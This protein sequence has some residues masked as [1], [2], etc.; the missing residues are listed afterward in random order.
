MIEIFLIPNER[1]S[2]TKGYVFYPS[3][4]TLP[5]E[6]I[7]LSP[8]VKKR[9]IEILWRLLKDEDLRLVTT[10][11]ALTEKLFSPNFLKENS[12][13]IRSASILTLPP[14]K[15][16]RMGY[17]RTFT[18]QAPGEFS[19][20]GGIVDIFSP[21]YDH[22]IRIEL[23]GDEVEEIRFFNVA[24]QRS[25]QATNEV[26][27]LPFIDGYGDNTLLDFAKSEVR[28]VC[29]DNRKVLEEFRKIR[30]EM[31]ELLGDEYEKFFDE[32]VLDR[33]LKKV[34]KKT[35]TFVIPQNKEEES[36][37]ILD[38]DEIAEGELV[39][40]REHGVAIFE[41][42]VRLK[43]VLGERDYL[44]LKYEDSILYVPVEKIDRVH[45]YIGD[46]SQV[47]LDRLNRG[48]WKQ[49]LKKVKEN[50]ERKIKELVELYMKRQEARGIPLLGDPE[51]E[52]KFSET[53]SYIETPDQERCIEE[54]LADLAS[55][56]PMDRLLCGDAGVGKT[57]V[58]LRAA[59]RTVVSGKQVVVLVPTT[60]LARQHYE[61]FKERLEPFG[62][63]VEL[64]DSS[65]TSR[66]RKEV[67]QGLKKGEIDV[68]IG[69]HSLLNNNVKFADVGLVI[70]D[71]EQKFGV[72]QKEQFKKMRLNVNV[73]SL[74]ATP[75]PRTLHMALS[76]MKDFSVI[77]T[78][79]PGR[80]PVH[81]YVAEYNEDLI[82]GAVVREI[83]RGGQV[84]YVH[85]R[86]EELPEVFA[87][88]K[89]MFPELK[90][91]VAHG[92]M[93]RKN[94]EKV[95]HEFY[96]GEIDVLLCTTIIENGVDIPN[97]NT[98]IVDDAHRYG[99]AQLYQLRGRVG[100]S[101]RRAFAYFLYPKNVP[102][103]ALKRLKIFRSHTGPNSGLQIAMKDMELRGIGDVLGLE[104]HGNVVSIGLKLYNEMLKE[105]VMK[106]RGE[107][108]ESKQAINV[109]IENPPGRFFIPED[110][111]PNPVERLRMYRKLAFSATEEDLEDIREEMK[112]RFGEPPEEVKLLLNYFKLRIRAAELGIKKIRFDH[113]MVELFP[114]KSSSFLKHPR[115]NPR[116]GSV[117]LYKRGNPVDFLLSFL[118][119][120][121]G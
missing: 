59:F 114:S 45:K 112:D 76:G 109:E 94:M 107:Q 39:V 68:V 24:T 60:V 27:V 32:S 50:I 91:E 105:T 38:V 75:I 6:E 113:S 103:N 65:R 84:I 74:S 52:E 99:L 78:P 43:G 110:Y 34:A 15:L 5:S 72:E 47:K 64:L 98:L 96:Q 22:P 86:V 106:I 36:L 53:F 7:D 28:F 69:T 111:V 108:V 89:K 116:S 83:N 3:R 100:R 42:I 20:R 71:E 26:V 120:N 79:P 115:Y 1:F 4:D 95:I 18:V 9:R 77:N 56:K 8:N 17:E 49:T 121:E 85:N 117:V 51:L 101:D 73:L 58:A 16:V 54:V 37:P 41:G 104:Q 102:K 57:E 119:N 14:E 21:G 81:I 97:A 31:K 30:K 82:K 46:P 93:S 44:K 33:V 63:K 88:L 66:E 10:L 12:I 67:I 13:R 92:R 19:I 48:R 40:H 55:E 118:K 80:K 23:F 25:F 61:T 62:I 87:K 2:S 11:K 35:I 29:E 70:I 90:I